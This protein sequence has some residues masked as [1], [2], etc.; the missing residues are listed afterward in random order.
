[1]SSRFVLG[2]RVHDVTYDE[3][4]E[5]IDG[6]IRDRGSHMVTTPNPEFV[7]MARGNP[8]YRRLLNQAALAI[9][10]G[11]GLLWAGR[12]ARLPF[13]EHV[14]GT[15][16]ILRLARHSARAGH[17]WFLLGAAPGIADRA[18]AALQRHEPALRI[19]GTFAGRAGVDGDAET[20]AAISAAGG[21]DVLLVAFG[22]PG[23]EQWM[24]RNLKAV[25]VP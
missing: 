3:A 1:M 21:A 15:D 18:A 10:D 5:A 11:I 14:R 24:A 4:I 17:Q 20:R 22:A 16:L 9:P 19:A 13:R 8:E 7:M 12:L 2:V 25:N 6:F 23:Q